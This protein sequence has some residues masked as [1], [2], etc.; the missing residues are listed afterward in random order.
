MALSC[1]LWFAHSHAELLT[2]K[3]AV[4]QGPDGEHFSQ[5]SCASKYH[6]PSC[7]CSADK[8]CF[9]AEELLSAY[10]YYSTQA[11]MTSEEIW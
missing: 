10:P 6:L 2:W 3:K 8:G 4:L 7:R 9:A 1:F 5:G 11:A